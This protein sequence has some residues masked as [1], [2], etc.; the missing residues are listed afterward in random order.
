M[1]QVSVGLVPPSTA[2]TFGVKHL[3]QITLLLN[4]LDAATNNSCGQG[5]DFKSLKDAPNIRSV[6]LWGPL[7][8]R[9]TLNKVI[10]YA[11]TLHILLRSKCGFG[12]GP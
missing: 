12:K 6:V 7:E 1:A 3:L 9:I 2:E 5:P 8:P 11:N 4:S 10:K